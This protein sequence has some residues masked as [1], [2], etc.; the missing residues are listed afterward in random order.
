MKTDYHY[1]ECGLDD[2]ILRN[3]EIV[4]DDHGEEVVLIPNINSLHKA[5]ALSIIDSE[6]RINGKELRF[7]RTEMGRTQDELAQI[8]QRTRL[9]INRWES[10][11]VRMDG[12]A[13]TILR[14]LVAEHFGVKKSI[15]EIS[16]KRREKTRTEPIRID[17]LTQKII[18]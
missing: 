6:N 9:T 5:I 3:L 11:K 7:L 8:V 2:I 13:E 10:D 14:Q 17:C 12:A 1:T 15:Q 18:A 4:Q 16:T